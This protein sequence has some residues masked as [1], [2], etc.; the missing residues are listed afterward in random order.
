MANQHDVITWKRNSSKK[1]SISVIDL[2]FISQKIETKLINWTVD[3]KEFT[4]SDHEIIKF[5]LITSFKNFV[6]NS[7]ATS[8]Y[9][10]NK[11]NWEE[12]NKFILT[13]SN[14][15]ESQILGLIISPIDV[16]KNLKK[17]IKLLKN[18]FV[19]AMNKH[20]PKSRSCEKS[21]KR[22]NPELTQL[23]KDMSG[24][25]RIIKKNNSILNVN[26]RV[27]ASEPNS[28]G[29]PLIWRRR[30]QFCDLV[31]IRRIR[32]ES[33]F[34]IPFWFNSPS[35][36]DLFFYVVQCVTYF[37]NLFYIIEHIKW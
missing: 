17:T 30:N 24:K 25:H 14:E 36:F 10:L 3:E 4:E 8:K 27:A 31:L 6:S 2:I 19:M 23:R 28:V 15:F 37:C 12:F 29:I 18:L 5:N 20:I 33:Y 9:N 16:L 34:E 11:A 13:K 22:W 1:K 35:I 26:I 21:K 7:N 32:S